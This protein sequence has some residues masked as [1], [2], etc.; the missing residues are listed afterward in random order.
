[1][2]PV[3]LTRFLSVR[4]PFP[5]RTVPIL[6]FYFPIQAKLILAKPVPGEVIPEPLSAFDVI[7]FSEE[8]RKSIC[9]DER[10]KAAGKRTPSG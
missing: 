4:H 8:V 3:K 9:S 10:I 2:F 7:C 6:F 1:M 5:T